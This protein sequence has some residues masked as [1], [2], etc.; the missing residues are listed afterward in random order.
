M[1]LDEIFRACK[2]KAVVLGV[3]G[4]GTFKKEWVGELT[5]RDVVLVYDHDDS[6]IRGEAKAWTMLQGIARSLRAMWWP[7]SLPNKF[8]LRDLYLNAGSPEAALEALHHGLRAEP[9]GMGQEGLEKGPQGA[10]DAATAPIMAPGPGLP[11]DQVVKAYRRWLHLP[12]PEPLDILF[13]TLLGNRLPGDPLW[14]FLVAPPGGSKSA[15]LM[16]LS[17][18]PHIMTTTSLTPHA[19]VSGA[20]GPGGGDPSLIPK[21]DGKV[22]VIKDFTSILSMNQSARDEILGVLR[23]AYDGE[24]TKYFGT[25]LVKRYH[26]T[27]GMVAGVTPAIEMFT[28]VHASLGERFL[29]YR[30]RLPGRV[31]VGTDVISRAIGNI[32]NENIMRAELQEVA[33]KALNREIDTTRLPKI[34][35]P[36]HKKLVGLAQWVAATR[37][38]VVREKYTREM[39]FKPVAEIGSRIGVQLAKLGLGLGMYHQADKLTED[40]YRLLVRV[41]R[42]TVPD[43]VEEILRRLWLHGGI[44]DFIPT[45]EVVELTRLNPETC[46]T[47]LNDLTSLHVLQRQDA[48]GMGGHWKINPSMVRVMR[49]LEIYKEEEE[50]QKKAKG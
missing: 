35:A 22:L 50:W 31:S 7:E 4:A 42:D 9:R 27:F 38:V 12:N 23:D 33:I 47:L 24:T 16:S 11:R 17:K 41:A 48:G 29:R 34:S 3:T 25:G 49:P 13:A 14:L 43:R 6:G 40:H 2:V 1:A 8:D 18:A 32:A 5:G 30:I 21:L 39:L 15:M 37:A 45:S 28:G 44:K 26:S 36:F 46:R 19:L 10:R 20:V